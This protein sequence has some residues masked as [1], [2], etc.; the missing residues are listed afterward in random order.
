MKHEHLKATTRFDPS[1]VSFPVA[2][3]R[4]L[5][6]RFPFAQNLSN[7]L[8]RTSPPDL[9]VDFMISVIVHYQETTDGM[10][11]ENRHFILQRTKALR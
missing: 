7:P 3:S 9:R 5:R 11:R 6:C 2:E 4:P 10:C 8:I 1:I